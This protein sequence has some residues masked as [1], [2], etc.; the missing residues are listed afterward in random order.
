MRKYLLL[1]VIHV[2]SIT[3][4]SQATAS[5][6]TIIPA[7]PE[8]ASMAKASNMDVSLCT[9]MASV[10]IPLYDLKIGKSNFPVSINYA[11]N[12]LKVDDI[13]SRSGLGW[14]LSA[15]GVIT[16]TI[17][18]KA[19]EKAIRKE[20]AGATPTAEQL[21][22]YYDYI[23]NGTYDAEPDEFSISAPGMSGKFILDS[24]DQALKIPYNNN[25]IQ[26]TKSS[27]ELKVLITDVNG[28]KYYFGYDGKVE[29]T[30]THNAHGKNIGFQSLITALFLTKILYPDG[31]YIQFN[32]SAINYSTIP[33]L[34][35]SIT[36]GLLTNLLPSNSC[37][38]SGSFGTIQCDIGPQAFQTGIV[39][40]NYDSYY[41]SSIETSD[42]QHIFFTYENRDDNS[43]DKRLKSM[44][45]LCG[46]Y[47]KSYNFVYVTPSVSP[48]S[49]TNEF[50]SVN[51]MF[52]LKEIYWVTTVDENFPDTSRYLF[53]Y[54][55]LAS[56]PPRLNTSQD[57]MGYY[58]AASNAYLLPITPNTNQVNWGSIYATAD[59]S[60]NPDAA[61]IGMLTRVIYPTGGYQEFDY[62]GNKFAKYVLINTT[63][64]A[65]ATGSGTSNG[66]GQYTSVTHHSSSFQIKRDQSANISLSAFANP[67]CS[68]CTPPPPNT[69]SFVTL[70]V[71][72]TTTNTVEWTEILRDYIS[73]NF[74]I[75]L[76][77]G[78]TYRLDLTV[79][80]VPNA[81]LAEIR[82]DTASHEIRT[83]VNYNAYGLRVKS[84]K[85]FDPVT[86][87]ATNRY[88]YYNTSL[89][90]N[91][92][93]AKFLFEP[94]YITET[95][96]T[97][98][99][100]SDLDENDLEACATT[101]GVP[102]NQTTTCKSRVLHSNTAFTNY[103]FDGSN[104][105]YE[106]VFESD[107]T[108]FHNGYTQHKYWVYP[109]ANSTQLS[110]YQ[111]KGIPVSTTTTLNSFEKETYYYNKNAS[112]VKSVFNYYSYDGA[113]YLMKVTATAVNKKYTPDV[114]DINNIE[115]A[116]DPYD[117]TQY[118][119]LSNWLQL[120]STVTTE[121]D[122]NSV[123]LKNK[124]VFIYGSSVNTQVF[125]TKTYTSTGDS[126]ISEA[127]YPTDYA[128]APY[129]TMIDKNIISPLVQI[130][131]KRNTTDLS[132]LRYDYKEWYN[133]SSVYIS[134]PELVVTKKGSA[135]EDTVIH[136]YAYDNAGNPLE[137]SKEWGARISYIWDY[138]GNF[139][140]AEIKNAGITKDS[141]AYT[142]F[143]AESK[144]YWQ[145][146]GSPIGESFQPMGSYCYNLT[147]GNITRAINSSKTYYVTYWRKNSSGSVSVN[148]TTATSLIDR[149]GWTCYQHTVSG[150]S[151]VTVSGTGKL[152]E[153]RLYPVGSYMTTFTYLPFVG[154]SG[155]NEPNNQIT[156]YQ[157]DPSNRLRLI[158]DMDFNIV[159][160]F[161]Y[162]YKQVI[163]PC[164]DTAA[165]WQI[166]GVY[167]CVQGGDNNN[168][169]GE[170]QRQEIDMNN[171]SVSYLQKRWYSLG[172]DNT[173]CPAVASCTGANKRVVNG[174]C[175]T[176]SKVYVGPGVPN[177]NGTYTCTYHYLWTDGFVS[178]NY[179]EISTTNCFIEL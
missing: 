74:N 81:A 13:P 80:G 155:R 26:V 160:Q 59:R 124:V 29:K 102:I 103:T 11:S 61:K 66:S 140:T 96:V 17:R 4:F 78:N 92:S 131:Q 143:E 60:P 175:E 32:Y 164:P 58:N 84:I 105:L 18:G 95:H 179:T 64:T 118:D 62:E 116:L 72:N 121:Y 123:S 156:Y 112:L 106:N 63:S 130:K 27:T 94:D 166:T 162:K 39:D 172:T 67:G 169:T 22:D 24:N 109:I 47:S 171:C 126:L 165:N 145:F 56:L 125:Q 54:E 142:S 168:Y 49:Y 8:P 83:W 44:A 12:G 141:I 88:F 132:L 57:H 79:K 10:S 158:R 14:T 161:E 31:S 139:A 136:Y 46:S 19:D 97:K 53:A 71:L 163:K 45:I 35:Q 113:D 48:T 146:S 147:N 176:G 148:G 115:Q 3:A 55:N 173:N 76:D 25:K 122:A 91:V 133:T 65:S 37:E 114:I 157:Y 68:T 21:I 144:G 153:L 111:Q 36:S 52:F 6:P 20:S 129:T 30:V 117:V 120:D 107:D 43:D 98:V 87:K 101:L 93:S 15:G 127:K 33:G 70:E 151:T 135:A 50:Y 40:I 75:P 16:R 41:L 85:S 89:Q 178:P 51:K 177:G 154:P 138:N 9:G 42:Y 23:S 1:L 128:V 28:A 73:M 2:L 104:L 5:L 7:S 149:N 167:R 69:V 77:S 38:C 108:A 34:D 99:C 150:S 170:R 86:A 134:E 110:G 174:V 82:Y 100:E 159:K 119:Y 152:D 90:S 137:V